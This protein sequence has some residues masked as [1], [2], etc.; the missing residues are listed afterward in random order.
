LK[1]QKLWETKARVETMREALRK[2]FA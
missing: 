2:K 1:K